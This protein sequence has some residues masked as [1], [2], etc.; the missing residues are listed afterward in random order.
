M[1]VIARTEYD[2][3]RGA[4]LDQWLAGCIGAAATTLPSFAVMPVWLAFIDNYAVVDN[5]GEEDSV[6]CGLICFSAGMLVWLAA[7]LI[8]F[9][10]KS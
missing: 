10:F 9:M 8:C 3:K 1:R 4:Q 6:A 5:N 7:A 2:K